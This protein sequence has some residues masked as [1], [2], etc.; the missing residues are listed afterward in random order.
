[1]RVRN[2]SYTVGSRVA[3]ALL[4][5]CGGVTGAPG[6][7]PQSAA[8]RDADAGN[9]RTIYA[10][11]EYRRGD[12]PN[13]QLVALHGVLYGTSYFG[14][15][16]YG[17]IFSLTRAGQERTL[18]SF[19]GGS[20]GSNPNPGLIAVNGVLYGT[21]LGDGNSCF[22]SYACGTV[23][24]VTTSGTERIIYHFKGGSD[25]QSPA[26]GL[27]WLGG[28]FYGTTT[29]GGGSSGYCAQRSKAA[30]GTVFSLD[31]SGNE[32][33]VYR[34]RGRDGAQPNAPLLALGGKLY[35]TTA[36]GGDIGG[37][38]D[39]N[40]GTIFVVTTS[41]VEKVLHQFAGGSD[42]LI[43]ASSLTYLDGML[44][45][46]T[47][48]GGAS[49]GGVVF[50]STTSGDESPIYEF[51]KLPDAQAPRGELTAYHGVLYGTASGGK[52]CYDG[53]YRSGTIFAVTTGGAERVAY[54]YP[55]KPLSNVSPSLL[56]FD[57]LLYGTT[58]FGGKGKGTV[59]S[60]TP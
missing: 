28:R 12:E 60:F 49:G 19:R 53:Y 24:S 21:T 8:F 29:G 40:C 2:L 31:E 59:F 54:T 18:Y 32:N 48:Q 26:G 7:L 35:G 30:C 38:C 15:H 44:Y 16:G 25:G 41:G 5:G 3:A 46:T 23:F 1:M 39:Y 50:K 37:N 57:D 43:P 45:G 14:G 58:N 11:T 55:C 47:N 27:I 34:F 13:G 56:L 33:I 42:G 36:V 52:S 22:G 10:F 6:A 17:T 20:D 9:Y 51:K 4:A